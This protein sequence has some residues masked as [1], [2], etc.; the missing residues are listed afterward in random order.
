MLLLCPPSFYIRLRFVQIIVFTHYPH[1]LALGPRWVPAS[2][3]AP[4]SWTRPGSGSRQRVSP[5]RSAAPG[6]SSFSTFFAS[7]K[8]LLW[9]GT[10]VSGQ[11][12]SLRLFC[13]SRH[14]AVLLRIQQKHHTYK[15]LIAND[16]TA[17][18]WVQGSCFSVKNVI[19][20]YSTC[21]PFLDD[22][23]LGSSR[24]LH[25]LPWFI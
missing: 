19:S 17:K 9:S 25:L 7:W 11:H 20:I 18:G 6:W 14:R 23:C 13:S 1:L 16:L 2:G 3:S 15:H 24:V 4:L 21:T 10:Q 22:F 5:A 8:P 12:R